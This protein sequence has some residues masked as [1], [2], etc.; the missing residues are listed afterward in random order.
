MKARVAATDASSP[1][2]VKLNTWFFLLT[3][4]FKSWKSKAPA[5]FS[6]YILFSLAAIIN[7]RQQRIPLLLSP[8]SAASTSVKLNLT[9]LFFQ[10]WKKLIFHFS[11]FCIQQQHRIT[12][13]MAKFK[14]KSLDVKKPKIIILAT[15]PMRS[16]VEIRDYPRINS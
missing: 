2:L 11:L 14:C 7:R 4:V 13:N 15:S 6:S 9:D 5:F 1:L 10:H 12:G 16:I 3:T 8:F